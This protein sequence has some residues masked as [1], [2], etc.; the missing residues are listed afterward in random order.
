MFIVLYIPEARIFLKISR[1]FNCSQLSNCQT[2]ICKSYVCLFD[3]G[4]GANWDRN[5]Q[6]VLKLTVS[7]YMCYKVCWFLD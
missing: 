4:G 3:T 5:E 2:F 1:N 6:V 7:V